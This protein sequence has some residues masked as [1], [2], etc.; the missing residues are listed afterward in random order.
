MFV[1]SIHVVYTNNAKSSKSWNRGLRRSSTAPPSA[2]LRSA[3]PAHL[4]PTHSFGAR[5]GAKL[6]QRR[7]SAAFS[8][9]PVQLVAS[10]RQPAAAADAPADCDPGPRRLRRVSQASRGASALRGS[11]RGPSARRR[12]GIRATEREIRGSNG[13]ETLA[14]LG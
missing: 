10:Q 14:C 13:V 5:A 7:R 4:L 6:E 3:S 8:E 9:G 1:G 12:R 11:R 2:V